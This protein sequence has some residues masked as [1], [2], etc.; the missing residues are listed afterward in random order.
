MSW[1]KSVSDVPSNLWERLRENNEAYVQQLRALLV[2]AST[3]SLEYQNALHVLQCVRLAEHKPANETE[4]SIISAFKLA[5]A[6]RL[7]LREMGIA[8]GAKIEPE[9][10][11]ALLDDTAA[12]PGVFAVGC[13]GAGGYDAVFA[14]V[15]GDANCAVVEQFWESYTKLNVC[16]LLVREDCGGLLIGTV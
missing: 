13:P 10:L 16:P 2:Q 8:A 1:F 15:I 11:I 3:C 14:L 4:E 9:E 6:G 5:A 7:Y 12:L